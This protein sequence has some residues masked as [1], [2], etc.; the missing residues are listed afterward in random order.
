MSPFTNVMRLDTS[1]RKFINWT[2]LTYCLAIWTLQEYPEYVAYTTPIY[3]LDDWLNL[4]LDRYRMH[5]DHDIYQKA[6]EISCSDYR[7]VYMGA[8]GLG[9]NSVKFLCWEDFLGF[10][11]NLCWKL[12]RVNLFYGDVVIFFFIPVQVHGHL[13]MQTFSDHIV[14]QPMF[15]A[16][17]NGIF[18]TQI[19]TT[20]C[21]TGTNKF[22]SFQRV[23]IFF[24]GT[25]IKCLSWSHGKEM[26][27]PLISLRY[28]IESTLVIS[29]WVDCRTWLYYVSHAS[30]YWFG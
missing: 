20:L 2:I 30:Q 8:K 9:T 22:W 26:S 24:L 23:N 17:K 1:D 3:F 10:L 4:Y 28:L 11:T 14:G 12:L 6:N 18:W 5:V 19:N 13:F 29:Q 7:F 27:H 21:L 25:F 15:V 16:G